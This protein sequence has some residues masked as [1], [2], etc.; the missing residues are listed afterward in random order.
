MS[1]VQ[2]TTSKVQEQHWFFPI[3]PNHVHKDNFHILAAD[4]KYSDFLNE[5]NIGDKI[6]FISPVSK[7]VGVATYQ[8]YK[9]RTEDRWF[10]K[11]D[12]E[13]YNALDKSDT[14]VFCTE[15]YK[16]NCETYVPEIN[17]PTLC[18]NISEFDAP[19]EY[20]YVKK[21]VKLY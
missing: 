12:I 18:T 10:D 8:K 19:V 16:L 17:K 15:Y 9:L 5:V 21:F 1:N 2:V 14:N 11:E 13:E 6:W 3:E 7:V 4:S 20:H